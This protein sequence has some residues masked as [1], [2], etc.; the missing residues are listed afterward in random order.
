M[1]SGWLTSGSPCPRA[2]F[3]IG[4][5]G[6]LAVRPSQANDALDLIADGDP[7]RLVST[8]VKKLHTSSLTAKLMAKLM[9]DTFAPSLPRT[10]NQ[11]T[12]DKKLTG[13]VVATRGHQFR[14]FS[15][16][17]PTASQTRNGNAEKSFGVMHMERVVR[18][19]PP[20]RA[21]D[22]GVLATINVPAELQNLFDK[23]PLRNDED[24]KPYWDFLARFAQDIKPSDTIDWLWLKDVVDQ[25]WE[26]AGFRRI[27][28]ALLDAGRR[29]AVAE[30]FSPVGK[31][32][33]HDVT[34][35]GA[36]DEARKR[37]DEWCDPKSRKQVETRLNKCGLDSD[38]ITAMSFSMQV[39]ALE[40]V[41]RMLAA[42]E[43]RRNSTLNEI[44][45]RR[46]RV[47]AM[48]RQGSDQIIDVASSS[49]SSG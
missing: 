17:D 18:Y 42:L 2:A 28:A 30:I 23:T 44:E 3:R 34:F 33:G 22:G 29:G 10:V 38:A 14:G 49:S 6:N 36:C 15:L 40:A 47:G 45:N 35:Y 13:T 21:K 19:R 32:A 5:D 24:P 1:G 41:E 9:G 7:R 27:K 46:Q 20:S 43:F 16:Q 4:D 48:L 31:A 26:I 11:Q 12:L 25:S 8:I 39:T 37:A